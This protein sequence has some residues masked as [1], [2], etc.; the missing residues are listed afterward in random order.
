MERGSLAAIAGA[1]EVDALVE[2]E[3]RDAE[4]ATVEQRRGGEEREQ[5]E[6]LPRGRLHG[7]HPIRM[8][9][10]AVRGAV[11]TVSPGGGPG[12]VL[13]YDPIC[14]PRCRTPDAHR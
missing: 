7:G 6:P 5:D 8:V 11:T 10:G 12:G 2:L 13:H 4:V 14:E 3:R 9:A 1:G